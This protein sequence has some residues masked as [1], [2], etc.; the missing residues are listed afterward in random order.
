MARVCV[1]AAGWLA[2]RYCLNL[3]GC[4]G[5][6]FVCKEKAIFQMLLP[7]EDEMENHEIVEQEKIAERRKQKEYE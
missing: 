6:Q 1:H 7:Q 2:T 4:N 3:D 5:L